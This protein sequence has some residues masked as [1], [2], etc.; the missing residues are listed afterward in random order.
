M[1]R[2]GSPEPATPQEAEVDRLVDSLI[3]TLDLAGRKA[4]WKQIQNIWNEQAWTV[5][6]PTLNVKIP[7]S[8]RFGNA[9]PSIMAHR[10]IWNIDRVYV[11]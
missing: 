1:A 8:N 6:L 10:L 5:W 4:I 3:T 7:M 11:K 9:Q 2:A